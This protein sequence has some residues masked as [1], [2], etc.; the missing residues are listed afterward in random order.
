M[1][2]L[3]QL[4]LREGY[5]RNYLK[6]A[7]RLAKQIREKLNF[8]TLWHWI[9]FRWSTEGVMFLISIRCLPNRVLSLSNQKVNSIET[10]SFVIN[11]SLWALWSTVTIGIFFL[12]SW[13]CF[14]FFS[15]ILQNFLLLKMDHVWKPMIILDAGTFLGTLLF[16]EIMDK[17][18]ANFFFPKYY[19]SVSIG[20]FLW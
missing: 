15:M 3:A 2:Y 6:E 12:N 10:F 17:I 11:F 8:S 16:P 4:L 18:T 13:K 7:S 9:H 5:L 1:D 20:E 19:Y 14:I